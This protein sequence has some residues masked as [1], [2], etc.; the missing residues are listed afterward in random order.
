MSDRQVLPAD[1]PI[2]E[3]VQAINPEAEPPADLREQVKN[4][5]L[6][7]GHKPENELLDDLADAVLAVFAERER[8]LRERIEALP[9]HQDN[10][11][12]FADRI[13]ADVLAVF[14]GA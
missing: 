14:D 10:R 1:R 7:H 6:N 13:K 2:Y 9:W 5:L 12:G 11:A 8:L 4:A 3:G